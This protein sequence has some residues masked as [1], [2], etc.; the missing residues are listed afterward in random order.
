[1]CT[2]DEETN[3]G[4][5]SRFPVVGLVTIVRG[6]DQPLLIKPG[7][8]YYYRQDTGICWRDSLVPRLGGRPCPNHGTYTTNTCCGEYSNFEV[9]VRS[10]RTPNQVW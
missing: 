9:R 4:G 7:K 5:L 2:N 8:L 1:M 6:T 10:A 3:A